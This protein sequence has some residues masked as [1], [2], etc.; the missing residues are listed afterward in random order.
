MTRGYVTADGTAA[1][2]TNYNDGTMYT[3]N[4]AS[5][6]EIQDQTA[7]YSTNPGVVSAP[8]AVGA[9]LKSISTAWTIIEVLK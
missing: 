4:D 8:F 2:A 9:Q 5:M 7:F 6:L 1:D 3:L